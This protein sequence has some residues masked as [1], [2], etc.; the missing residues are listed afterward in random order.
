MLQNTK[1]IS[2]TVVLAAALVQMTAWAQNAP[3][4]VVQIDVENTVAYSEDVADVSK[5]ATEPA[6]TTAVAGR[7][8]E[9]VIIIG[10]TE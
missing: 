4:V 9:K 5:L 2:T 7:T 1:G 3:P 8:F 6:I 10:D